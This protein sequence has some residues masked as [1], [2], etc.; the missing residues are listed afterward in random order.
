MKKATSGQIRRASS[1][2]Q[3]IVEER[4]GKLYTRG[5]VLGQPMDELHGP[6]DAARIES[7]WPYVVREGQAR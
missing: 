5:M 4:D 3:V 7:A 6:Y 2:G 1:G